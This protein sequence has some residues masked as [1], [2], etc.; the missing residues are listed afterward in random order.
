[1]AQSSRGKITS[2]NAG[3][4]VNQV[5]DS[6]QDWETKTRAY[7]KYRPGDDDLSRKGAILILGEPER[8]ARDK[9]VFERVL[10]AW[11][12]I[13]WCGGTRIINYS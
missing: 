12:K 13:M 7:Y 2:G 4:I 3:D 8:V 11:A 5:Y 10:A 6:Y 9:M 1:M